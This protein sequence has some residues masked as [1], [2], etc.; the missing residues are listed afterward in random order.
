MYLI[1]GRGRRKNTPQQKRP[2]DTGTQSQRQAPDDSSFLEH[3]AASS[4]LAEFP[5]FATAGIDIDIGGGGD[6]D[7]DAHFDE[8]ALDDPDLL[9]EFEAL[10]MHVEPRPNPE[11]ELEAEDVDEQGNEEVAGTRGDDSQNA[12]K[13]RVLVERESQFKAAA[14]AAKRAGNMQSARTML[15]QMKDTQ[16]AIRLLQ[17]GQSLPPGYTIPAQPLPHVAEAKPASVPAPPKAPAKKAEVR[18]P[19][20][21][22]TTKATPRS[23]EPRLCEITSDSHGRG[24]EEIA[25]SFAAMKSRLESQATEATRL[26]AYFLRAGDKPMA[27]EFHRLKKRAVADIASVTSFEANGRTLPPPFLH[28]EVRWTAPDEQQRRDISASE[29]QVSIGRVVSNGDLAMALGGQSDFFIQWESS[30]PRDKGSKAYT[31]TIKYREFEESQ[32]DLDI[33]Y[34]RNVEFVDRNIMRPLVRWVERGKLVIELYK[35]MGILWGSQLIGRA[36]LPL[37]GLRT[38]AEVAGLV[39]IKAVSSS[40]ARTERSLP[41][42]PVFVDVAARLRLPLSNKPE[43]VVHSERW[44]YIDAQQHQEQVVARV[45]L[46]GSAAA[47]TTATTAADVASV[48]DDTVPDTPGTRVPEKQVTTVQPPPPPLP[49]DASPQKPPVNSAEPHKNPEQDSEVED[50]AAHLDSME[51]VL[52]NAVL[53]FELLQIPA[54]IREARGDKSVTSDLQDLEASIKLRMSVVAAQVGAGALTIDDYM[55]G[56]EKEIAQNKVWAL[57]A[58]RQGNKDL[59]IR[60]L[61]R[62]KAMQNEI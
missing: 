33:G 47:T 32:G 29:M 13:L 62:V 28:R 18:P 22:S 37:A 6:A 27:L 61:K 23:A 12:E 55:G 11:P 42:G 58:K 44:I 38:K 7:A 57:A 54:R 46:L 20:P 53:E 48:V 56:V 39:E 25:T 26:S 30:W 4:A 1:A 5:D 15:V 41:G 3:A 35:Y 9:S 59:A 40:L 14:L 43:M 60:A 19:K 45:Q 36:S 16:S 51:S 49:Q 24:F 50:I 8:T 34:S 31:R 17:S 2:A 10:H 52:S 21:A